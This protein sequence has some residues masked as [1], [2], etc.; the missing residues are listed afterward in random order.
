MGASLGEVTRIDLMAILV[1]DK[2]LM[3]VQTEFCLYLLLRFWVF[4]KL[5]PTWIWDGNADKTQVSEFFHNRPVSPRLRVP[6]PVF[7]FFHCVVGTVKEP[8]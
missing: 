6:P 4:L 8:A 7:E 5:H 3:V 2:D 1:Q